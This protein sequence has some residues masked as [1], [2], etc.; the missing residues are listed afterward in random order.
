MPQDP[1][2]AMKAIK[3]PCSQGEAQAQQC[4]GKGQ[5]APALPRRAV[6]E[7]RGEAKPQ[8]RVRKPGQAE[9]ELQSPTGL[10]VDDIGGKPEASEQDEVKSSDR[11]LRFDP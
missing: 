3:Q 8:E 9:V 5:P 7:Q 1:V 6:T 10:L 4:A 2:L 11:G